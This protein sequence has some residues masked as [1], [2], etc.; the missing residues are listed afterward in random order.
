M[1]AAYVGSLLI[2]RTSYSPSCAAIN[3]NTL[4]NF[5]AQSALYIN[6]KLAGETVIR[7]DD[8]EAVQKPGDLVIFNSTPAAQTS[9][10]AGRV[11]QS[12]HL[13]LPRERLERV[14]NL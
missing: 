8:R 13:E 9:L 4:R 3:W 5:N 14:M 6:I 1:E 11:N 10:A 2:K 7:Q 12:L